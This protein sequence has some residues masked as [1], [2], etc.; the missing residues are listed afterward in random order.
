M[1]HVIV[2]L[3]GSHMRYKHRYAR[4]YVA[5]ALVCVA[6]FVL[7]KLAN[8]NKYINDIQ[9]R[10]ECSHNDSERFA[11]SNGTIEAEALHCE[12]I[13]FNS[14]AKLV[15]DKYADL[16][17]TQDK[18]LSIMY[19]LE[20]YM[21]IFYI[22]IVDLKPLYDKES[23][24]SDETF[25]RVQHEMHKTCVSQLRTIL[26]NDGIV[27]TINK[28]E[29][30]QLV[31]SLYYMS[32]RFQNTSYFKQCGAIY[33][34][35]QPWP[36]NVE[37]TKI[38]LNIDAHTEVNWQS[39]MNAVDSKVMHGMIHN[40]HI[41]ATQDVRASDHANRVRHTLYLAVT[42]HLFE[43]L[44]TKFEYSSDIYRRAALSIESMRNS[45]IDKSAT[46]DF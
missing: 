20:Y 37:D 27:K 31:H 8:I 16:V 38:I 11:Q 41:F 44:N 2:G 15:H 45:L 13:T 1:S 40:M 21:R 7:Y 23:R 3:I 5:T 34:E 14:L 19:M 22:N 30:I 28:L 18:W 9:H 43:W 39:V 33:I 10:Q 42:S 26:S 32:I 4:V 29:F 6:A 46:T 35:R 36:Y 25:E 17:L 12:D 24:I